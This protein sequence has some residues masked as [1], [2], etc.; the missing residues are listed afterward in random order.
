MCEYAFKSR[1]LEISHF[2]FSILLFACVAGLLTRNS[3]LE[4]EYTD[5]ECAQ[6]KVFDGMASASIISNCAGID[7]SNTHVITMSTLRKFLES[8]QMEM[9]SED[10]VRAIIKVCALSKWQLSIILFHLDVYIDVVA[11]V[12][13]HS[14]SECSRALRIEFVS[15]EKKCQKGFQ[16]TL[17]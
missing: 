9:K 1:K 8:R 7:T 16:N 15:R 3:S 10:E 2:V 14:S 13:Y 11:F 12:Y 5:A 4:T 17:I 6:K